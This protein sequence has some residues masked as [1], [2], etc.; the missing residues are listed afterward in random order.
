MYA[1][2]QSV[3]LVPKDQ[4]INMADR[5]VITAAW[6]FACL[7]LNVLMSNSTRRRL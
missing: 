6:P 4:Q 5:A 3:V 1:R 2:K 7:T